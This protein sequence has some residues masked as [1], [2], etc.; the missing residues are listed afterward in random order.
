MVAGCDSISSFPVAKMLLTTSAFTSSLF[1]ILLLLL[2]LLPSSKLIYRPTWRRGGYSH[3]TGLIVAAH[4]PLLVTPV[5]R[6]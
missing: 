3:V 4:T 5:K 1:H 6:I 2:L